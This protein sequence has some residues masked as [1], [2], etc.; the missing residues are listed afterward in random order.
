M[1][2]AEKEAW[3]ANGGKKVG[4]LLDHT[5]AIEFFAATSKAKDK[6]AQLYRAIG[7]LRRFLNEME[8]TPLDAETPV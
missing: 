5:D 3:A 1:R 4:E 7:K 2:K 6:D 8:K